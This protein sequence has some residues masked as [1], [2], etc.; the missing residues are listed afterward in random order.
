VSWSIE[1]LD[2]RHDRTAFDCGVAPLNN[3]IQHLAS[4]H[5]RKGISKTYVA[6]CPSEERVRGFYALAAGRLLLTD[7]PAPARDKLPSY[8]IPTVHLGQLA[9]DRSAQGQGLGEVLL[10]DALRRVTRASEELGVYAVTVDALDERA[11]TFY[12]KYG[13]VTID[14]DPLHLYLEMKII[15]QLDVS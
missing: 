1:R 7:L 4:Q 13:F 14:A 10:F 2:K 9:V 15:R 3:Y 12:L 6:V 5:A 11:K 8:P